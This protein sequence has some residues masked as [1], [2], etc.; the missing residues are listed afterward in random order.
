MD[1]FF[2]QMVNVEGGNAHVGSGEMDGNGIPPDFF[3]DIHVRN[4]FN[5]CF[6]LETFIEEAWM[7][8][9][10]QHRGPII[11]GNMGYNP[12]Q[13]GFTYDLAKCEEE[14][15]LAWDG[16]LWDAGFYL[17][18]NYNS[19]NDQRRTAS[20]ILEANIEGINP[21]F[22]ISVLDVPWPT[23]LDEVIGGRLAFYIIGWG[24]DY[25]HPHNWVHPYLHSDGTWAT[26]QN[27]PEEMNAKYDAKIAECL[28][29]PFE[30]AE[31][32]YFDLNRWAIED[33]VDIF[34]VQATGRHYEQLW[35]NGYYSNPSY[36]S[37]MYLYRVSKG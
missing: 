20:E 15:K 28:T 34:M 23:Y 14:F 8:E 19:G 27:W 5:Y 35:V 16:E 10:I 4:A 32:C 29:T 13:E 37:W 12:D 6:D 30:E 3:S 17:V 7:G 36:P 33:A 22:K 18:I 21:D 31:P 25:H 24:E 26:F 9:G 2:N 11:K 1:G